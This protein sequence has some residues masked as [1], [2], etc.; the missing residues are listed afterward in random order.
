MSRRLVGGTADADIDHLG[1][2]VDL[3][4]VEKLAHRGSQSIGR[5]V[6]ELSHRFLGQRLL[7]ECRADLARPRHDF[8]LVVGGDDRQRQFG[9][10]PAQL[11]REV[12]A[13]AARHV[14]VED[15]EVERIL[16]SERESLVGVGGL[17]AGPVGV[18]GRQS[19]GDGHP[20]KLAV[21]DDQN[22]VTHIYLLPMIQ[23]MRH[24]SV[25]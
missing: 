2:G 9:L 12:K 5:V 13:V 1:Q 19:L 21:V 6:Q 14:E 16:R 23:Q 4:L 22:P 3:E 20:R 15:G 18:Q 10:E 24:L 7:Q 25:R 11:G 8:D 17:D